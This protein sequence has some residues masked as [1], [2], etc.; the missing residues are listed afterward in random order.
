VGLQGIETSQSQNKEQ[1]DTI[2]D[3]LARNGRMVTTIAQRAKQN[4]KIK[5]PLHIS[6]ESPEQLVLFLL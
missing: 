5:D 4:R 2:K 1:K 3:R 6:K